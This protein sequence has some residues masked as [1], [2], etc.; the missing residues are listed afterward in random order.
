MPSIDLTGGSS[1]SAPVG[2]VIRSRNGSASARPRR[3]AGRR[4]HR[5]ADVRAWVACR[6]QSF[7][8]PLYDPGAAGRQTR[9]EPGM[10]L[11]PGR[12]APGRIE[13][14]K[15][16]GMVFAGR[17]QGGPR[18]AAHVQSLAWPP[19]KSAPARQRQERQR[20]DARAV[21][22]D[23]SAAARSPRRHSPPES[24]R[25]ADRHRFAVR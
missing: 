11:Q 20:H 17:A 4:R 22:R 23:R 5:G 3:T 2:S 14:G 15:T 21:V 1:T 18:G 16:R 25:S 12:I 7:Q 10:C 8:G 19:T 9:L 24:E 13:Q 6:S